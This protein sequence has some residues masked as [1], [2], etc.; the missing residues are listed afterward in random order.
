WSRSSGV[1]FSAVCPGLV[2]IC[3]F[4]MSPCPT[5]SSTC[6]WSSR[7]TTPSTSTASTRLC[8]HARDASTPSSSFGTRRPDILLN[9]TRAAFRPKTQEGI[10]A[11]DFHEAP[12]L[13][14]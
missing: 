2:F 11:G 5:S 12:Q 7:S 4:L 10:Q 14:Q 1:T 6:S 8:L 13:V 3:L 9:P